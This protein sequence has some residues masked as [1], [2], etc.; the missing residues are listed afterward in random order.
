LKG[1]L[2]KKTG[3]IFKENIL[4][5]VKIGSVDERKNYISILKL[6]FKGTMGAIDKR[7]SAH[8]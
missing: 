2:L 3:K 7:E 5:S 1:E 6:S 4:L 8:H